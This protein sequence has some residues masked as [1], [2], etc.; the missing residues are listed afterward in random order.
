MHQDNNAHG[1][2]AVPGTTPLFHMIG[3]AHLDPAWMWQWGEGMEAFLATCRSALDRMEEQADFI[4]TCSSAAHY[5][6]IE[7]VEP[8]LFERI[9]TEIQAGR[10]VI[11]GGWWT[12]ADCNLPSGEGFVRQALL[13]QR[14]FLSRFGRIARTGYSPDAFGHTLGLP[15]LLAGAGMDAY[16]FCRPDPTELQLPSPLF[17]WIGPANSSVLAYRVPFHYN[18][19]QTSVPK[20]VQDLRAALDGPSPLAAAGLPLRQFG[21]EW[22]LFYGVGNHGGGPT[23]E[24]IAQIIAIDREERS[25]HLLFSSPDAFFARVAMNPG[26]R[27]IPEWRDDLQ[28]NAPG[29]YSAHSQIKALNRR[30]EHLLASAERIASLASMVLGDT[31]PADTLRQAWENVCFNHFHD[32]LCGVAIRE[33]LDDAI[34]SYGE[35]L[36]IAKRTTRMAV[37]RIA[38]SIDTTGPGR[39]LIVFNP[40]GQRLCEHITFELW[41]DIDKSL[42]SQPIQIRLSDDNGKDIP[43]QIG[44]T[45]GKIGRD[46]I[47]ITFKAVLPELGWRCYRV[48]YGEPSTV[49]PNYAILPCSQTVLENE[50]LRVEF[51][52]DHGAI[53]SIID[54][55]RGIELLAGPT[56]LGVAVDDP[57]D[58]WGHGVQRFDTVAGIFGN[59]EMRLVEDGPVHATIRVRSH[60]RGSMVQQSFRL[61]RDSREIAV[62]VKIVW[63][64]H[65]TMLKLQFAPRIAH[66]RAAYESAYAVTEKPC[67]G[68]ER[69]GGTWCALVGG[70][71]GEPLAMAV[72]NDAKYGYSAHPARLDAIHATPTVGEEAAYT[73]LAM[74][75]VR[76]PSYATHDPHPYHPD[77]DLD[78]ID[79]GVQHFRYILMFPDKEDYAAAS[80][81][82]GAVLAAG[83]IAHLESAHQAARPSL[84][85]LFHGIEVHPGNVMV[86]AI[87]QHEDG[88]GWIIRLFESA[89]RA[90]AASIHSIPLGVSWNTELAPH[91]V[92]TFH[93]YNGVITSVDLIE[94]CIQYYA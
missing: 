1:A 34:E 30:S 51:S 58:T 83:P 17:R 26:G 59:A 20:K 18:M 54:R 84:P 9:R 25:P 90:T 12:Q 36:A 94:R 45:S 65:R 6:W 60:W 10:W 8:E 70:D 2:S 37:Q 68:V 71:P 77:E 42:W 85:G 81:S 43:C 4:F 15:Q 7:E 80:S 66:A 87:K 78:F 74:T 5:R 79:Q 39:T 69:P 61:H 28:L 86:T 55:E 49:I 38:R 48:F 64:E 63:A 89:G 16:I 75:A 50:Y 33:A 91:E 23:Q 82:R 3:N 53:I 93:I 62:D 24:Q 32:I 72:V 27:L 41:H 67:D 52:A 14:Y 92:R 22:M 13:G 44:Y 73:V 56:A 19:Y 21:T 29:C 31:Y 57:T 46:R 11:V 40:H 76:S 47:A 88:N 35:S